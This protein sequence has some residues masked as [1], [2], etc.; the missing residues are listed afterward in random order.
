MRAHPAFV[1]ATVL[2]KRAAAM[3]NRDT[4]RLD[5]RIAD[6]II[7]AS[8]EILGK[9]WRDHFSAPLPGDWQQHFVVDVYQAGAGTSHNMNANEV[10]ANRAI[11]ILGGKRG[12]YEAG[13]PQRPRQHG[14]VHQRHLSRRRCVSRRCL[15]IRETLPA[16][17]QL[18]QAFEAKG[19]EFDDILKSG[20]THL[21]DATPIRL[22]QEFAAYGLT[23]RRDIER[24]GAR[25]GDALRAEHRRHGG[26]HRPQRRGRATSTASCATWPS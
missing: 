8:D 16:M 18:A 25:A 6:A 20:R 23:V 15:M 10:L 19:R 14:A 1:R 5:A 24:L 4:G 3:A 21:Q 22:G 11:E 12:D 26:R 7:Q 13:Q 2:I 17:D 9:D